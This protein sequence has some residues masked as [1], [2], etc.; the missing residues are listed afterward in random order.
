M[1]RVFR[2]QLGLICARQIQVWPCLSVQDIDEHASSHNFD[3]SSNGRAMF[4]KININLSRKLYA[5]RWQRPRFQNPLRVYSTPSE[6]LAILIVL[7]GNPLRTVFSKIEF[8]PATGKVSSLHAGTSRVPL[9]CGGNY[10]EILR[11]LL[12]SKV[13][14]AASRALLILDK[15]K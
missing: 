12:I 14:T 1:V 3:P 8:F 11:C 5:L 2:A 6:R 4:Q 15:N 10:P 13:I 7:F 9:P